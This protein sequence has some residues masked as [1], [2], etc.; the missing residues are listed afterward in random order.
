MRRK[1]ESRSKASSIISR[2]STGK[3]RKNLR[4]G[5]PQWWQKG[6]CSG[7]PQFWQ[8]SEPAR[9]FAGI[10]KAGSGCGRGSVAAGANSCFILAAGCVACW[11]TVY[12]FSGAQVTRLAVSAARPVSRAFLARLAADD[13]VRALRRQPPGALCVNPARPRK[14]KLA[15]CPEDVK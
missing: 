10:E 8:A 11:R 9:R 15:L 12:F 3:K 4:S 2:T 14:G 6:P 5:W 1:R 13:A 7:A